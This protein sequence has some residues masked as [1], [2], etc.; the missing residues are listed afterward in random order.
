M[1]AK[2]DGRILELL[3]ARICHELAGPVSAIVN[4]VELMSE[5]D[6]DFAADALRLVGTSARS[7]SR[8]LQ[9]YRFAYGTLP[10]EG[11]AGSTGRDLTLKLFEG[12][13]VLCD[14]PESE[15]SRTLAWQRLACGMLVLAAEA[16]PR[17]GTVALRAKGNGMAIDADGDTVRL[18]PEAQAAL[19]P[20]MAIDNLTARGVH[21]YM[22]RYFAGLLNLKIAPPKAEPRRLK[23]E[24]GPA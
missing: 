19:Q 23:I 22:C 5:D 8:R 18:L 13:N 3:S 10:G 21:A 4:G 6:S 1:S 24:T 11:A 9:F 12:G 2:L 20:D 16:L 14:W 15:N 7:A 17:G